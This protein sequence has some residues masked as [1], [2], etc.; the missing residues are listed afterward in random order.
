[1]IARISTLVVLTAVAL[2]AAAKNVIR[3]WGLHDPNDY[4]IFV[5]PQTGNDLG[6]VIYAN[7]QPQLE[8]KFEAYDGSDPNQPPG[9]INYISLYRA[10][11]ST[12]GNIH[13]SV[14]GDPN[15]PVP[16]YYGAAALMSFDLRTHGEATNTVDTI[17]ISGDFGALGPMLAYNAGTVS[18]GGSTLNTITVVDVTGP[19]TI[20]G[21][22][23]ARLGA[24]NI[25]GSVTIGQLAAD[26]G[27]ASLQDLTITGP[28]PATIGGIG[29]SGSYLSPYTMEIGQ[30]VGGIAVSGNL[31]SG[32]IHAGAIGTLT[33]TTLSASVAV[34]EDL[35]T[36]DVHQVED[37]GIVDVGGSI[38]LITIPNYLAG[39]IGVKRGRS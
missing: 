8:W 2:P 17:L 30:A 36:L 37:G 4:E 27:C 7:T 6:V 22:L 26:L 28:T 18:I 3:E 29:I 21:T 25:T 23:G 13:L 15:D 5:D 31:L 14:I 32:D 20:G 11:D 39:T 24:G 34:D 1:M 38:D 35:G 9:D 16:H 12:V 19:L 33:A 10:D